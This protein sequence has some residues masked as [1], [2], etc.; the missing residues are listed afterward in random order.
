MCPKPIHPKAA[1]PTIHAVGD[2]ILA[3]GPAWVTSLET[4]PKA[5]VFY[6]L[7]V[8]LS[9]PSWY[10]ESVVAS[11]VF[12]QSH[13]RGSVCNP[14]LRDWRDLV[15]QSHCFASGVSFA[16][17]NFLC[18]LGLKCFL[19]F[20]PSWLTLKGLTAFGS[21]GVWNLIVSPGV[22]SLH[23][24]GFCILSKFAWELGSPQTTSWGKL[25]SSL[26]VFSP[27]QSHYI[28]SPCFVRKTKRVTP[29]LFLFSRQERRYLWWGGCTV[30]GWLGVFSGGVWNH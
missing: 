2:I 25:I 1:H 16:Q 4:K 9:M 28:H 21:V 17:C 8:C 19:F 26:F 23:K 10:S 27:T 24:A 5:A 18:S 15:F 22:S 3:V 7:R 12:Q 29:F 14:P 11:K 13:D 6:C 20:C 30:R